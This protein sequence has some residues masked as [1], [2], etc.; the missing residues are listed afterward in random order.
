MAE[1]NNKKE[2]VTVEETSSE[3]KAKEAP[4]KEIKESKTTLVSIIIV[5]VLIIGALEVS[6]S[7][8]LFTSSVAT[9]NGERITQAEYDLRVEQIFG[10][11]QAQLLNLDDPALR[12][13]IEDQILDEI[14]N[15][16]LL[17]QAANEAGFSATEAQIETEYQLIL[18]RLGSPLNTPEEKE[19]ILTEELANNKLTRSTF[20]KNI[21]DQII[22]EQYFTSQIDETLLTPTEEEVATYHT[23]LNAAQEG[24]PPLDEIRA[25]I[26][27]QIISQKRQQQVGTIIQSLRET[28]DI[29]IPE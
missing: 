21:A 29:V 7:I 24:V 13:S 1:E 23:Q 12:K 11:D 4:K 9:V 22:I 6:G 27:S 3:S 8:N 20:R 26:E 10:S 19:E 16:R 14:I 5:L 18:E 17:L 15:T 2:E 28:A 25:E